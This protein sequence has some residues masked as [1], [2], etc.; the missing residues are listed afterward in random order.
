M[1]P[2]SPSVLFWWSVVQW[3]GEILG[4]IVVSGL[5]LMSEMVFSGGCNLIM[6]LFV[7]LGRVETP[8]RGNGVSMKIHDGFL[9]CGWCLRVRPLEMFMLDGVLVSR[10]KCVQC[11]TRKV[12]CLTDPVPRPACER[13]RRVM[14]PAPTS[15]HLQPQWPI[16]PGYRLSGKFRRKIV[17]KGQSVREYRNRRSSAEL[18]A[19]STKSRA[20]KKGVQHDLDQ[21]IPELAARLAVG[22]CE[23]TGIPFDKKIR[24]RMASIDRIDPTKGYVYDNIRIICFALNI[25]FN[26]WGEDE[27]EPLVRAWLA[28]RMEMQHVTD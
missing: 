24:A 1:K 2:C 9:L 13:L 20:R 12:V 8:L 21:H 4:R 19:M 18:L 16:L 14:P 23:L 3:C 7:R 17:A 22:R 5:F 15:V 25:A 10:R 26:N 28:R 27:F 11:A 6:G